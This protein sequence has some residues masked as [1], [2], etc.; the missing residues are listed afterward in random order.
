M[1]YTPE[2]LGAYQA[3][4]KM[5]TSSRHSS[6]LPLL[7]AVHDQPAEHYL[8]GGELPQVEYSQQIRSYGDLDR[9]L[10]LRQ[11]PM[12]A[13]VAMGKEKGGKPDYPIILEWR[14]FANAPD[15]NRSKA[16]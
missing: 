13:R 8:V 16:S 9:E 15:G 10:I 6:G 4:G 12:H 3:L 14:K 2:P 1:L 5:A 11:A 7:Q